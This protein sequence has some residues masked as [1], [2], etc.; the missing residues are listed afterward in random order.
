MGIKI[1]AEQ[2]GVPREQGWGIVHMKKGQRSDV[3]GEHS[4]PYDEYVVILSGHCILRNAGREVEYCTGDI[5]HFPHHE[6]HNSVE[7]LEDTSYLWTRG[8]TLP[9]FAHEPEVSRVSMET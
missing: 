6:A 3:R 1:T 7:A 2:I 9:E 8:D 4:H 5:G